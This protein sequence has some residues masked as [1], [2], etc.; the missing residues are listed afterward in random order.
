[1]TFIADQNDKWSN[2]AGSP[3][4]YGYEGWN[5]KSSDDSVLRVPKHLS[6]FQVMNRSSR[7]ATS[8]PDIL[9]VGNGGMSAAEYRSYFSIWAL[10]KDHPATITVKESEIGYSASRD[11]PVNAHDLWANSSS[12]FQGNL[13]ASLA[14][15]DCKMYVLSNI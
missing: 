2:N 12:L 3:W 11:I 7:A 13:S 14:L 10:S 5:G 8:D 6:T 9:Q 15:R 1:M 4:H